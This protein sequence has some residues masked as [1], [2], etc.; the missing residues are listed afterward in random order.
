MNTTPRFYNR[1]F[2]LMC[3]LLLVAAGALIVAVQFSNTTS[4]WWQQFVSQWQPIVA[5]GAIAI[6]IIMAVILVISQGGG[7][8]TQVIQIPAAAETPGAV[9]INVSLINDLLS[10]LAEHQPNIIT[11]TVSCFE[12]SG[13]RVLRIRTQ[14]RNGT[15]PAQIAGEIENKL[16]DMDRRL[17]QHI[18]RV[19]ELVSGLRTLRRRAS[20]AQ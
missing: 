17:G 14:L 2:L 19:I 4:Q 5:L 6:V 16:A 9:S 15:S 12:S 7:N 3:G 20:T 18:P 8:R 10:E 11:F 13:S 1:F